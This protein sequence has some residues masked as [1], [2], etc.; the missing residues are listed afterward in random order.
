MPP[1]LVADTGSGAPVPLGPALS[2]FDPVHIG[3]DEFGQPKRVPLI[4]RNMLIG[5]DPGS[6]KSGA[7]ERAGRA[8]GPVA[9]LQAGA[10]RRQA[11][12]AGAVA[13]V[14]GRVRRPG[15]RRPRCA[16]L[17]RLQ[18]D[19][20]QPVR[21]PGGLR[22]PEDHPGGR[23]PGRTWSRSMRSPTS[24]PRSATS[25]SARSS[26]TLLRDLVARGR[27]VGIIVVAATQRPSS[28]TSS[29]PRCG[30]CSRGGSPALHHRQLVGHRPRARLGATRAGRPTRSARTTPAP[31]C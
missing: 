23:V 19:D 9:G 14:R 28:R 11:G 16:L 25:S 1:V 13:E 18:I 5:G 31:A 6:G 21:L 10:A 24:R 27:A 17:K 22:T 12:R 8:R 4:D 3:I 29:R 20:G 26:P 2:I 30:I 15:H 7:A